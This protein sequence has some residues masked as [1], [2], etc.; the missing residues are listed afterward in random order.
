MDNSDL[1]FHFDYFSKDLFDFKYRLK[2]KQFVL[3]HGNYLKLDNKKFEKKLYKDLKLKK[4]SNN[5]WGDS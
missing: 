3:S 2:N 5:Y 1:I 4:N